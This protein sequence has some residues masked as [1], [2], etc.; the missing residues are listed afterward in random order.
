MSYNTWLPG[1]TFFDFND[2]VTTVLEKKPT[3]AGGTLLAESFTIPNAQAGFGITFDQI[4][5]P[6]AITRPPKVMYCSTSDMTFV[7]KD[8]A[9]WLWSAPCPVQ[10]A[11]KERGWAWSQFSLHSVQENTGT[12][13]TGPAAGVIQS[14]QFGGAEGVHG[15]GNNVAQTISLGYIAGRSPATATEGDIRKVALTDRNAGAHTWKVGTVELVG[16]NRKPIKYLGAL[17]FGLQLNGPRN[18]LAVLPYRG[19]IVAGY[20]SGTAWV[21]QGD[22]VSL[23]GMLNFMA[24]AQ[25]QFTSRNPTSVSGPF[26]HIYLQAL[27]DCEQNGPIDT[28][29]WD[30]PDGNPAWDG[31]QYRAID[32]MGR[33][34]ADAY[35]KSTITDANKALLAGI[36]TKFL[37]WLYN[38]L[39]ANPTKAGV[40]NSWG[41]PGWSQ[42][43]PLPASSYLDPQFTFTSG[44]DCA[45]AMKGA[46]FAA[47]AGYSAAKA[48][49][50]IHRCILAIKPIQVDVLQTSNEMRGAFTLNPAGFEVYGFEQ[51]EILEALALCKQNPALLK[52]ISTYDVM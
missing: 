51:G 15:A 13:P 6:F 50:I 52:Q 23:A 38:W 2:G 47:I 1:N 30:G 4:D 44:H 25:T 37:D 43:T 11:M 19:P 29:V 3:A 49:Y 21:G 34:W 22:N 28:W 12:A 41:P 8:A 16:G 20:Q 5:P 26:M 9:G 35:N 36:C 10:V 31:W 40:P 48:R 46:A 39:I 27:W 7:L 42:G 33:T 18:R 32:A 24:D 45:L 14:Y 17:P